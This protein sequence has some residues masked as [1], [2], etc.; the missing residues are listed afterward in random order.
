MRSEIARIPGA[1]M[2]KLDQEIAD[3][4]TLVEEQRKAL[5]W[6]EIKLAALEHAA[7][8]RPSGR[9]IGGLS[10]GT[11]IIN[12]GTVR[13]GRQPGAISR[14]WRR[15]LELVVQQRGAVASADEMA[16]LGPEAGM[17]NLT[18]SLVRQR[19]TL[20]LQHGYIMPAGGDTYCV[21]DQAMMRFNLRKTYP[22]SDLINAAADAVKGD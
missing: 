10:G 2:D 1:V 22:L 5:E 21:T 11:V 20:Y 6:A 12:T 4:R 17:P 16:A 15:L 7:Q 14:E 8:L 19:M 3:M 13:K 9:S 18:A